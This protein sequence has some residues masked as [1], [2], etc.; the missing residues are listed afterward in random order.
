[1]D[2]FEQFFKE[3][4]L[5]LDTEDLDKARWEKISSTLRQSAR[6][7]NIRLL[8]IAA[9]FAGVVL[10]G[11]AFFFGFLKT[12]KSSQK[13]VFA[14]MATDLAAN[15]T[16]YL[17]SISSTLDS[18]RKQ[19]IPADYGYLFRDF[20]IQ[21]DLID[22]QYEVYKTELEKHGYNEEM[23]QQIMY[24]YQ[25]KLSVLHSLQSEIAKINNLP[26]KEENENKKIRINL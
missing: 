13:G 9:V 1:M 22:K 16:T 14:L 15:E 12:E 17:T 20:L 24:N 7:G 3:N 6:R 25:L 5:L 10:L 26:K 2:K 19:R 23:I 21:L 4:R 18:I 11:S 8:R